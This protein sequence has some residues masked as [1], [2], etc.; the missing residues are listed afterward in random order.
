MIDNLPPLGDL[1]SMAGPAKPPKRIG[2]KTKPGSH[3]QARSAAKGA[4]TSAATKLSPASTVPGQFQGFS[5]QFTRLLARLCDASP[6]DILSVEVLDDVASESVSGEKLLEQDKST[7]SEGNPVADRA[8]PLWNTFANWVTFVSQGKLE[9][10]KTQFVIYV[11]APRT[12]DLVSLFND[13]NTMPRAQ[14]AL[15]RA[16][17]MLWGSTARSSARA[18]VST[19]LRPL[20]K[21]IFEADAELVARIIQRF[22]LLTGS[23]SPQDDLA[24]RFTR[25]LVPDDLLQDALLWAQG[26]VKEHVDRAH[27]KS[28]PAR[29]EFDVFRR[30]LIAYIRR[31]DGRRILL[32]RAPS[33]SDDDRAR[34][35]IGRIYLHQLDLIEE[36][37]TA[38]LQAVNDYLR[39]ASDRTIWSERGEVDRSSFDAH[40]QHLVRTWTFL[41]KRVE[42]THAA[43]DPISRG[44]LLYAECGL[45][46][47]TLEGLE[48]PD[49]FTIGSMHALA[50]VPH[51]GW[52]PEYQARLAERHSGQNEAKP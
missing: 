2:N 52:H 10:R 39:A 12:G 5:V 9:P 14:A 28:E 15:A 35:L 25:L 41:R 33:P 22:S 17:T 1:M 6:G 4:G 38:K 49:H 18:A 19:T 37:D 30:E 13:A 36:D 50:D 32:S 46:R 34:E 23:G 51:I 20:L 29:L 27:E 16:G 40:E 8:V 24:A 44:K 48:V 42:V 11:T 3:R 26:W 43:H 7:T 31:V 47:S 21:K 45:Y